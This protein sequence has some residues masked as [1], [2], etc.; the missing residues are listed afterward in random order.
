MDADH[1][2]QEVDGRLWADR[3]RIDEARCIQ[4]GDCAKACREENPERHAL[5][6]IVQE[7]FE[8]VRSEAAVAEPTVLQE[9][10]RMGAAERQTFWQNQFR[11]CIKCYGCIDMCPVYP[12]ASERLNVSHWVKGGQ[13]PPP[14]PLFHLIR[15]YEVGDACILCGE[16][17]Q[18]CPAGIPLKTLQD[19]VRNLPPEKVFEIIPGLEKEAQDAILHDVEQRKE[20]SGRIPHAA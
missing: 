18:T 14:Y 11:K 4:C 12:E 2:P 13:V 17:E 16:C 6:T 20:P 7:R 9:I 1:P 5:T 8:A 3:I 15:A 10:L 19:F